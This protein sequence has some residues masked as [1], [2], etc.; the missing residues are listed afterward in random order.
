MKGKTGS[1]MPVKHWN[2]GWTRS[3]QRIH[4]GT[5]VK[6]RGEESR[7]IEKQRLANWMVAMIGKNSERKKESMGNNCEERKKEQKIQTVIFFQ[8]KG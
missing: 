8:Q 1:N 5:V 7:E 4:H 6:K 2:R 3:L